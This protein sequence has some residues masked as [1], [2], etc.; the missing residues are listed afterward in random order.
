MRG[1]IVSAAAEQDIESILHWTNEHF[2][3]RARLRYEALLVQGIADLA[4]DPNRPGS[5]ERP[6]IAPAA[7][8]YHLW[9]SRRRVA[10][11]RGRVK[12]PRHF[13]LF[14]VRGDDYLEI[15]RVLHDSVE[16][17]RHLP[18]EYR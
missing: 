9:H 15:S 14:R 3:E 5:R 17:G 18:D 2:G 16:L 12:K 11:A 6:E 10:S 4:Q 13:I 8:T 7:R 1:C